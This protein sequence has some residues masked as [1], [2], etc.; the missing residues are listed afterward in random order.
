MKSMKSSSAFCKS[1]STLPQLEFSNASF[2]RKASQTLLRTHVQ[3]LENKRKRV[4]LRTTTDRESITFKENELSAF[5]WYKQWWP[6]QVIYNLETDRPNR[7][8]LLGEYF[9]VWKSKNGE[10]IAMKDSCP[11]KL[12]PLSEG[13]EHPFRW[14]FV[15]RAHR[16]WHDYVFVPRMEVRR[17]RKM[18]QN[19]TGRQRGEA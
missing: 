19:P 6:A 15:S 5:N 7:I 11:H 13:E 1:S 4:L 9:A 18:R 17:E 8:Q 14:E 16:G 2:A 3:E 12:A 10:W